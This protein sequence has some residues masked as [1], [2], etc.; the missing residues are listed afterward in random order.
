MSDLAQAADVVLAGAAFVEKDATFTNADEWLGTEFVSLDAFE[1]N[2]PD[3]LDFRIYVKASDASALEQATAAYPSA[4]VLDKQGFI[5][6]LN[7]EINQML[8]LIYAMLALAIVIYV[9]AGVKGR[10]ANDF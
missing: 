9:L 7:A 1:A 10:Y 2:L 5:D 8:G 3:Q 6:S 4:E